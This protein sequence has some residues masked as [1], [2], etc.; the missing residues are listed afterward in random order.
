MAHLPILLVLQSVSALFDLPR[1]ET[2]VCANKP[3]TVHSVLILQVQGHVVK[4]SPVVSSPFVNLSPSGNPSLVV[5][6]AKGGPVRLTRFVEMS[7]DSYYAHLNGMVSSGVFQHSGRASI[8]VEGTSAWG[9]WLRIDHWPSASGRHPRLRCGVLN[10]VATRT[11]S[12]HC[13]ARDAVRFLLHHFESWTFPSLPQLP[14]QRPSCPPADPLPVSPS[15]VT[16]LPAA[17]PPIPP[18]PP[19]SEAAPLRDMVHQLVNLC[20]T[21][22][23][24]VFFSPRGGQFRN[25]LRISGVAA[26]VIAPQPPSLP[27]HQSPPLP[28]SPL[29]NLTGHQSNRRKTFAKGGLKGERGGG[30]GGGIER[31]GLR[32]ALP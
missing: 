25:K 32:S 16:F 29:G 3:K 31:R 20:Q 24:Q 9:V 5:P 26:P 2:A 1:A 17:S 27:A 10:H 28:V 7:L 6:F 11:L 21:S 30:E 23:Q 19:P 18:A 13:I 22:Q 14:S 4:T 15:S 8:R 12:F